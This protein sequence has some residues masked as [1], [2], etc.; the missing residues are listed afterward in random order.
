MPFGQHMV[1]PDICQFWYTAALFMPVK[2]TPKS[3]YVR[4][5]IGL[6]GLFLL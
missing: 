2:S 1:I 3:A 5:K 6:G 4:N